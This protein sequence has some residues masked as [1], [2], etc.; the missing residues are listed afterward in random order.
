M[1]KFLLLACLL[2]SSA[3]FA[4]EAG[5]PASG[6]E[7]Q[8][9]ETQEQQTG[10][11]STQTTEE[12]KKAKDKAVENILSAC[13][14][15][16]DFKD[17][18]GSAIS[19]CSGL[20][21]NIDGGNQVSSLNSLV[22]S[23]KKCFKDKKGQDKSDDKDEK[24]AVDAKLKKYKEKGNECKNYSD[25]SKKN[26]NKGTPQQIEACN[27]EKEEASTKLETCKAELATVKEQTTVDDSWS[28]AHKD[29]FGEEKKKLDG[30]YN[31]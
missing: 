3:V 26:C 15:L 22:A 10:E 25:T 20:S 4:Q 6:A 12:E 28:Q 31:F 27:K 24:K 8:Q 5:S 21:C 9:E 23:M 7:E 11:A 29:Y 13:N 18:K 17:A 16:K 2:M 14:T 1:K 19:S 30:Q